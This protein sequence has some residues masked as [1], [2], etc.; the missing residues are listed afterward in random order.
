M[1]P[2]LLLRYATL[3]C[4]QD[5]SEA[6]LTVAVQTV[7]GVH[8]RQQSSCVLS[9][10]SGLVLTLAVPWPALVSQHLPFAA[11]LAETKPG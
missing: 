4:R 8:A 10:Y 6:L 9:A 7:A 2:T 1:P 11:A 3:A 5:R